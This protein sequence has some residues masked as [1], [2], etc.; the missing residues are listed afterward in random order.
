[1]NK[2]NNRNKITLPEWTQGLPNATKI[3]SK[4][5]LS[6]FGYKST[7]SLADMIARGQLPHYDFSCK[8]AN[9][10][11]KHF[12][13]LGILRSIEIKQSEESEQ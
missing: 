5:I 4:E 7:R 9:K 10:A 13:S 11:N 8:K 2:T 3:S 1:V 12:W 6:F